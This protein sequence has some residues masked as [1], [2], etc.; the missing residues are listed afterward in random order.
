MKIAIPL[1]RHRTPSKTALVRVSTL[2]AL[3]RS[4]TTL[5]RRSQTRNPRISNSL[6]LELTKV[7]TLQHP[8]PLHHLTST[9]I[10]QMTLQKRASRV[11][12]K[13]TP[14]RS[15]EASRNSKPRL[16]TSRSP[17]PIQRRLKRKAWAIV[18]NCPRKSKKI[19]PRVQRCS[20][21]K[22]RSPLTKA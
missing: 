10:T 3:C 16:K 8:P 20:P 14:S 17:M 13:T 5:T 19:P 2:R 22:K 11:T 7:L 15:K 12:D 4:H 6:H 21:F 9:L 18:P 1:R